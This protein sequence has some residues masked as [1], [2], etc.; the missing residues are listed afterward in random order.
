[1]GFS[2]Q[3]IVRVFVCG[4]THSG[5]GLITTNIRGSLC[6]P[7]RS[8]Q[9]PNWVTTP[10]RLPGSCIP[11]NVAHD[12]GK[13]L[14]KHVLTAP[15]CLPTIFRIPGVDGVCKL[16]EVLQLQS[17]CSYRSVTIIGFCVLMFFQTDHP[18]CPVP[19]KGF[20]M[21]YKKDCS[22]EFRQGVF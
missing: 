6:T 3:K 17:C 11:Q 2:G 10:L 8:L 21:G 1:M 9:R 22:G 5:G 14:C 15:L 16:P 20:L 18:V 19:V 4:Q 7:L 12:P 13:A